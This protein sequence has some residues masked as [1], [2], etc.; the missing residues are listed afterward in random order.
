MSFHF[1]NFILERNKHRDLSE[2]VIKCYQESL[3]LRSQDYYI[4]NPLI[5]ISQGRVRGGVIKDANQL[6]LC[7]NMTSTGKRRKLPYYL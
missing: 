7:N 4:P 2:H 5:L 1:N 3:N 6:A